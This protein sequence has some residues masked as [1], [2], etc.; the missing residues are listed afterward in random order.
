MEIAE[1]C[2]LLEI[3][4]S[5]KRKITT[6]LCIKLAPIVMRFNADWPTASLFAKPKGRSERELKYL[7]QKGLVYFHGK[8]QEG[9][10]M[11]AGSLYKLTKKGIEAYNAYDSFKA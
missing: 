3:K 6:E 8:S 11:G 2:D 5:G 4:D 9:S 7:E 1:L 10:N